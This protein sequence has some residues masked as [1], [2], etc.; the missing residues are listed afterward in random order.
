MFVVGRV[1]FHFVV[2]FVMAHDGRHFD[3]RRQV[4]DHGVQHRL[5]A[6]VLERAAA[7]HGHDFIADGARAQG[8]LQFVF[9]KCAAVEVALGEFWCRFG[10]LLDQLVVPFLRLLRSACRD[11]AIAELHALAG[12]VPGDRAHFDQVDHAREMFL[13]ADRQ[14]D[15]HRHAFQAVA[16][17]LAHAQKI[18]ADPVHLV[19]EG[20]P[21][22]MV[23]VG[24]P[25][26]RFRLRLH[27]ADGV[28]DH[29]GAVEHAHRALHFDR[30]VHVAG[31]VDD[32]DAVFGKVAGHAFP[33]G[34][35]GGRGDGDAALL[36]LLHP[37]HGGGAI[38][39][40][41]NLVI[42]ARIEQDALGGGGLAGV[43]MGADADITV[44]FDGGSAGHHTL[45]ARAGKIY[46]AG[47]SV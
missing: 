13:G 15:R 2:V 36:L 41:A 26:D 31:G 8:L 46:D 17:L 35:G 18:G 44:A 9:G 1:A 14:L 23:F 24:L 22:N 20:D 27:P 43:D 34:G 5:H 11:L 16:D 33:E 45:L 40:F 3:R 37:V 21:R 6:L 42:D 10:R 29:H 39:H 7:Q 32:I 12:V 28:V 38:V 30:E 19:D 25:P 4:V 47:H